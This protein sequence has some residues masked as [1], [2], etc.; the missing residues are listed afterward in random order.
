MPSPDDARLDDVK[1]RIAAGTL[2]IV[3]DEDGN[4]TFSD[5]P[6][7]LVDLVRE[8]TDDPEVLARFCGLTPPA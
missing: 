3:I 4:V 8:L 2:H 6:A 1:A 5:L 7:D